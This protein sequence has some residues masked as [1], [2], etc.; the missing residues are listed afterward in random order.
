MFNVHHFSTFSI[1]KTFVNLLYLHYLAY[2]KN[3]SLNATDSK[4]RL[5]K[6]IFIRT[7]I[8]TFAALLLI[9]TLYTKHYALY[10]NDKDSVN[11]HKRFEYGSYKFNKFYRRADSPQKYNYAV[12][13]TEFNI[14]TVYTLLDSNVNI[15]LSRNNITDSSIHIDALINNGNTSTQSFVIIPRLSKNNSTNG[16]TLFLESEDGKTTTGYKS[17]GAKVDLKITIPKSVSLLKSIIVYIVNGNFTNTIKPVGNS[18][19]Q[20]VVNNFNAYA[21][22]LKADVDGLTIKYLS[23]NTKISDLIG[24]FSAAN[25]VILSTTSASI[26]AEIKHIDNVPLNNLDTIQPSQATNFYASAK[27]QSGNIALTIDST[28]LS[29]DYQSNSL[30]GKFTAA[31]KSSFMSSFTSNSFKFGISGNFT[32]P[33]SSSSPRKS[34]IYSNNNFGDSEISFI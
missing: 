27:S 13:S 14:V 33:S 29:G 21:S 16:V 8:A 15:T 11:F 30:N 5:S 12:N 3:P 1:H 7:T 34:S 9:S 6:N 2:E 20:L 19:N 22:D 26:N 32:N 31:N 10:T 17:A 25:S 24:T 28:G 23:I 4:I 18:T